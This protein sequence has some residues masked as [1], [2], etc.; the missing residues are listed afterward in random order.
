M[1]KHKSNIVIQF[2][3]G[4]GNFCGLNCI[5]YII[6]FNV[7]HEILYTMHGSNIIYILH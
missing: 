3:A 7:H 1:D 2:Q 4:G 6:A 5:S